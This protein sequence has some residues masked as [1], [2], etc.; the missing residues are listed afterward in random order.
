MIQ[1]RHFGFNPE[2]AE[3]NYYQKEVKGQSEEEINTLATQEFIEMVAR[4]R[5]EGV[6][7]EVFQDSGDV[8]TPDAI[9]PNNWISFHEDGRVAIYP[10]FA[11]TRRMERRSD[12]VDDLS[13][14]YNVTELVDFTVSETRGKYLEGT[15]SMVLDRVNRI[16]YAALSDRTHMAPLTSFCKAFDF[17]KVTFTANQTV[18]KRRVPIYHTNVMMC[19]ANEFCVICLDSIDDT[20]E[21]KQ[22]VDSLTKTEK[23]IIPI[24]E[25]QVAKFAGNMLQVRNE[26]GEQ[27]TIM[28]TSAYQALN[29]E[30][31]EA[32]EQF[33]DIVHS[34]LDTIEL[35]G[36]GS[37]RC[38][39]AEIFN[40]AT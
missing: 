29:K 19:L 27:F 25:S 17:K 39:M 30:Q 36:G 14:R 32:I 1:P 11:P 3:N 4:I 8:R 18:K 24:S 9:F 37:A 7:V 33:G 6:N 12:L 20:K 23:Q 5:S 21:K 15:G 22:V 16:A 35:A 28:S 2:T 31:R 34:P 13:E 38:M 26:D 40:A 10:M